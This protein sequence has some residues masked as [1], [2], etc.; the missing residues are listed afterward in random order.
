MEDQENNSEDV[1]AYLFRKHIGLSLLIQ[2]ILSLL[3]F[4]I[5]RNFAIHLKTINTFL[6]VLIFVALESV[7]FFTIFDLKKFRKRYSEVFP[8]SKMS[9][10]F[11]IIAMFV[12]FYF[13]LIVGFLCFRERPMMESIKTRYLVGS[14]FLLICLQA[15]SPTLSYYTASPSLYFAVKTGH[16]AFDLVRFNKE[17]RENEDAYSKYLKN[18]Q[19]NLSSTQFILLTAVSAASIIKD[20]ERVKL[21]DDASLSEKSKIAFKFG[22]RLFETSLRG[23]ERS[24]KQAFNFFDYGPIQW[25]HPSGA[26]EILLLTGV[27]NE[28]THKFQ[29]VLIDKN[30]SMIKDME[31]KIDRLPASSIKEYKAKMK[32]IRTG[33]ENSKAFNSRE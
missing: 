25:M 24:E 1:G 9:T 23:L 13:W 17:I 22:I 26:V 16:E 18:H 14:S 31:K 27:E 20:K 32:L 8:G 2:M 15:L 10:T 12:P 4:C 6:L 3:V 19:G 11:Y 30:L 21:K 7:S 5:L 33:F 28:I 29:K